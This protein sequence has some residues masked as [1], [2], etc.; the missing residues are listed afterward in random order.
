[1]RHIL[2][3]IF[4]IFLIGSIQAQEGDSLRLAKPII[5][6]DN[7]TFGESTE[8]KL[9]FGMKGATIEYQFD[10]GEW[11]RYTGPVI[12]EATGLFRAKVKAP[13]YQTSDA[14]EKQLVKAGIPFSVSE[15]TP[16]SSKYPDENGKGIWD[17]KLATT[18][19]LHEAWMGFDQDTVSIK[20]DTETPFSK[21]GIS[22]L[23]DVP[24]WIMNPPEG[25]IRVIGEN[26]EILGS[27][28]ASVMFEIVSWA[29]RDLMMISAP[30]WTPS[31][32]DQQYSYELVLW[33]MSLPNDHPGAGKNAWIFIDEIVI[34]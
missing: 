27:M 26:G 5:L 16:P 15:M 32:P 30:N 8:V 22:T 31:H 14:V 6:S 29:N 23:A 34:Y 13:G 1:M 25:Q 3:L 21:V 17:G 7:A 20:F 2:V 11:H 10:W 12:L 4:A 28:T 33:P 24:S 9:Y 19:F 18:S